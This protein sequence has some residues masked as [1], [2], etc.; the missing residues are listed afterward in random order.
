MRALSVL[1]L[2][3]IIAFLA[4]S[5]TFNATKRP[6]GYSYVGSTGHYAVYIDATE[7]GCLF[8]RHGIPYRYVLMENSGG[9][10]CPDDNPTYE[11]VLRRIRYS[12]T[13]EAS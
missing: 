7:T 13:V 2:L 6:A 1:G 9:Y 4:G 5:C 8:E 11:D 10:L 12:R 3:A